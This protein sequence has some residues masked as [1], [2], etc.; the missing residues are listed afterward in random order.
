MIS[1]CAMV[2]HAYCK[3]IS[4]KHVTS[5][6]L[7]AYILILVSSSV[8]CLSDHSNEIKL[9]YIQDWDFIWALNSYPTFIATRRQDNGC[10]SNTPAKLNSD[11][12]MAAIFSYSLLLL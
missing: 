11:H 12:I 5:F 9:F 10:F 8:D 7:V 3:K 1:C 6:D 2:L 4:G